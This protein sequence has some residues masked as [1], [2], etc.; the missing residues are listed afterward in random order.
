MATTLMPSMAKSEAITNLYETGS[1]TP[2][3]G[4]DTAAS[5]YASWTRVG[6]LLFITA[7]WQNTHNSGASFISSG[8]LPI[9]TGYARN[10]GFHGTWRSYTTDVAG[11]VG[12]YAPND[13][14][15]FSKG[16]AGV[17]LPDEKMSFSAFCILRKT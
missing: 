15:R 17:E 14:M 5:I 11:E 6:N 8:S 7:D 4:R 13:N 2:T 12:Q 3:F 10:Y 1:W 16:G 9:P